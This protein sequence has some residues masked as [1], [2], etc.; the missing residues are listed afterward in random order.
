MSRDSNATPE[1]PKPLLTIGD[2]LDAG[3]SVRSFCSAGTGYSHAVDLDERALLRGRDT[4][5]DYLHKVSLSC[6]I[7]GAPGGGWNSGPRQRLTEGGEFTEL[8]CIGTE[9][10]LLDWNLLLGTIVPSHFGREV[11][12][13]GASARPPPCLTIF[14]KFAC[15]LPRCRSTEAAYRTGT[16]WRETD[17]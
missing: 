14:K 6:P 4:A 2:Y 7:C 8:R 11:D 15:S 9:Q 5:I 1:V 10:G 13:G 12:A 16:V 17:V 3:V